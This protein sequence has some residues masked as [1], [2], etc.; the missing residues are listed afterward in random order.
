M[1]ALEHLMGPQA[2]QARERRVH[3]LVT[4]KVRDIEDDGSYRL[5]YLTMGA[6]E[7]SA[8]ARVMMPMAGDRRGFHALPEKGD[9]VVV[10][11]EL[12]DTNLPI[13]LGG[14]WN[15][16]SRPPDQAR[17][18]PDNDVRTFVSRS[19][20]ELTFDDTR[21]AELVTIKTQGGHEITLSDQPGRG[22][23]TLKTKLGVT[24]EMDDVAQQL[25]LSAPLLVQIESAVAISLKAT[26]IQ[27]TTTGSA[28]GS[29]VSIDGKP[30]GAHMHV[31]G[32]VPATGM[33]GPV[34]P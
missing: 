12:G 21:G 20:H 30:F 11:F 7:P 3:G 6:D 18:S 29:L 4:A 5:E 2:A 33:S 24:V 23:I 31:P 9:E 14:V 28:T 22:K 16:E 15:S 10:A 26:S 32:L 8:P 17:P 1:G 25:K 27:L 13:V 19:G 34:A